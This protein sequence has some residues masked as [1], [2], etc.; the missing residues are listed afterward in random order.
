ELDGV[1]PRVAMS[2]SYG[3]DPATCTSSCLSATINVVNGQRRIGYSPAWSSAGAAPVGWTRLLDEVNPGSFP[4]YNQNN[5][6]NPELVDAGCGPVSAINLLEWWG[7][8]VYNGNTLLTSFDARANYI[9]D[10][11]ST[12]DG[13][14]F[15][16]DEDL[17]D[18]VTNY[19]VKLYNAGKTSGYPGRHYMIDHPE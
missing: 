12:L 13:I 6:A 4:D 14:N 16:D 19:P 17:I 3:L 18:F 7:I 8:P 5:L 9:A 10:Q 15:T 2:A 11:M 1:A